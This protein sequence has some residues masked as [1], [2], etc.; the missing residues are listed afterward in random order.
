MTRQNSNCQLVLCKKAKVYNNDEVIKVNIGQNIANARKKSNMSQEDLAN[1]LE[2]SRQSISLWETDQT[3][4]TLDKLE[5]LCKVLNVSADTIIG[6]ESSSMVSNE[7][8][9]ELSNKKRKREKYRDIIAFV[10]A[11]ISLITYRLFPLGLFTTLI[12][13]ILAL[14]IIKKENIFAPY[15]MAISLVFFVASIIM[16]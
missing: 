4:P 7:T 12:S 11:C 9:Q 1:L 2:V 3:I 14:T 16:Y 13:F 6:R 10:L 15:S 8:L 5:T